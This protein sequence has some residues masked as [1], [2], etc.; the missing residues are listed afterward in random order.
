MFIERNVFHLKFG[1]AKQALVLWKEYLRKVQITDQHIHARL[2]TDIT[3]RGYTI[4]LELSYD[5]FADLEPARCLLTKQDG[6]KEFYQQ[7]IPLCEYAERTQY[8]LEL[9]Y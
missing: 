9:I 2:L 1:L 7:F 3:G 6:W 5:N 8:K 4:V